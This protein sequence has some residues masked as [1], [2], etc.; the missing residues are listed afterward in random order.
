M[1]VWYLRRTYVVPCCPGNVKG[2][3]IYVSVL[4]DTVGLWQ[5]LYRMYVCMYVL[6]VCM[7]VCMYLCMYVCMYVRIYRYRIASMWLGCNVMWRE[8]NIVL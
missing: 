5:E 8:S 1:L 6:Y 3:V 2:T 7:Y 4:L